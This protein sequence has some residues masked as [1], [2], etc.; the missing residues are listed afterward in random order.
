MAP[1]KPSIVIVPGSFC[2]A[3]LY[4]PFAEN[5]RKF[6]YESIIGELPSVICE[7]PQPAATMAED[8]AAFHRIIER[9]CDEDKRVVILTHSYGG[10]VGN[11]SA[12]GLSK[13]DREKQ[14][15]KGG[16]IKIVYLT[17]IVG[18]VGTGPP[19]DLLPDY[20][21]PKVRRFF[22]SLTRNTND[23][24]EQGDYLFL[25]PVPAAKAILSDL[26]LE[27]AV[28]ATEMMPHH[29]AVSFSGLL[30][31]PAYKSIPVVYIL[32]EKDKVLPPEYQRKCIEVLERES[33]KP[34]PTISLDSGHSPNASMPEELVRAIEKAIVEL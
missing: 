14:G 4:E 20:M 29:S 18:E 2:P 26:P 33:G 10:I 17:S 22:L 6:G 31:Y 34:V 11:E 27:E 19:L 9:L 3:F 21:I 1:T 25:D 23:V 5:L 30:T 7:P 13:K 28:Q 15:R 16:V 12:N 8:A 32:C 24:V